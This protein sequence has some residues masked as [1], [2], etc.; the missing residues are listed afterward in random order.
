MGVDD[1]QRLEDEMINLKINNYGEIKV[2]AKGNLHEL[3]VQMNRLSRVIKET[4]Q[5][6]EKCKEK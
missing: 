6:V 3:L 2:K 5:E 1:W 4:M